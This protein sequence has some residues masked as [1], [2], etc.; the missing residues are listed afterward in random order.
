MKRKIKASASSLVLLCAVAAVRRGIGAA[1]LEG[2]V[3]LPLEL[4]AYVEQVRRWVEAWPNEA[5]WYMRCARAIKDR[6]LSCLYQAEWSMRCTTAINYRSLEGLQFAFGEM[7]ASDRRVAV[8]DIF[9]NALCKGYLPVVQWLVRVCGANIHRATDAY[10]VGAGSKYALTIVAQKGDVALVEWLAR[11][12]GA[13]V[14]D[15]DDEALRAAA[16]C[17]ELPVARWLLREGGADAHAREDEAVRA[18]ARKGFVHMVR[19]LVGPTSGVVWEAETLRALA[20]RKEAGAQR[21]LRDAATRLTPVPKRQRID[22][23]FAR[24]GC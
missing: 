17:N 8:R 23:W 3:A 9:Y 24:Q 4:A 15:A 22:H 1:K 21:V 12:G 2:G 11:E 16:A 18:A 19:F 10:V 6:S 5:G 7:G 14:H 13:D 20:Q